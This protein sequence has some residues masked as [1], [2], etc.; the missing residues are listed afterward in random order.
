MKSAG[1][2]GFGR[3]GLHLLKYWIERFYKSGFIIKYI[4]DENL[5]IAR[6]F[7][8]IK[9]DKY[10]KINQVKFFIE[11]KGI[12]LKFPD[13]ID[14]LIEITNQKNGKISWIGKVD[15]F[16]ECSGKNTKK[17]DCKKYLTGK[18]KRVLI[19][20]TSWDCDKT[21]VF[22][23]NEKKILNQ[24]KIISYG[25]CTVNAYVPLSNFINKK[26]N[27]YMSDVNVVHNIQNYKL[28]NFNT[29]V[30][31]FCTL[32][33]SGPNLL[34]FLNKDNFNVNYTVIPYDGV[35]IIDFKFLL[36]KT[37]NL[38]TIIKSLKNEIKNG[39]LKNLYSIEKNDL[40]PEVH[41]FS[42]SSAVIIE[43]LIKLRGNFLY[44]TCY[45]DNENSVNRYYDTLNYICN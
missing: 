43:E 37:T 39:S 2:N 12:L 18:T 38:S 42:T 4:N 1:I 5:N 36:K 20:A 44:I 3:F 16:L 22:G 23:F 21:V 27:I 41:K 13:G 32:E 7:E 34:K 8:I 33:K 11:K 31:K 19:S 28:K 45:F 15:I 17:T 9:T 14:H 10:C 35:S 24:D 40:G 6:I 26:Y 25:S 30:R 29:L